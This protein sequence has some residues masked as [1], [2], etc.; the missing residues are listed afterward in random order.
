M[1]G[2]RR[3]GPEEQRPRR[4]QVGRREHRPAPQAWWSSRLGSTTRRS[5]VPLVLRIE[6][7]PAVGLTRAGL[8]TCRG[9]WTVA[10]G[11]LSANARRLAVRR[12]VRYK[13]APNDKPLQQ[14]NVTLDRA[15][16]RVVRSTTTFAYAAERTVVRRREDDAHARETRQDRGA[17]WNCL[18]CWLQR[19]GDECHGLS[20]VCR[21]PRRG[22]R[23]LFGCRRMAN[24]RGVRPVLRDGLSGV[25][26]RVH[27][28]GQVSAGM[29]MNRR[30]DCGWNGRCAMGHSSRRSS[31][32]AVTP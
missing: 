30:M 14:T 18:Q 4:F 20:F 12:A 22:S 2:H 27:D 6:E 25:P 16:G 24:G 8:C 3:W 17:L 26:V 1:H 29:R 23:G 28:V 10:L 5:G 15:K 7:R 19:R 32:R 13:G 31:R 11:G 21:P 9:A